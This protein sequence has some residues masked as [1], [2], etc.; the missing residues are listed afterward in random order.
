MSRVKINADIISANNDDLTLT[1]R[2]KTSNLNKAHETR[3]SLSSSYSQVV[4]I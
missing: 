3:D 4:L 2:I 1:V